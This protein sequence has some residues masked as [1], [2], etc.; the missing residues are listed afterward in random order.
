MVLSTLKHQTE[1]TL[2]QQQPG[3]DLRTTFTT[4]HLAQTSIQPYPN[5]DIMS[6]E[7]SYSNKRIGD[8]VSENYN[9]AAIFREFGIDFCCGG[10]ISLQEAC[11]KNG[12]ELTDVSSRLE[13]LS[14][15]N[16]YSGDNYAAWTPAFLIDYIV[17]THHQFVK[18][19][20]D[21]IAAYA[22]KVARVHGDRYPE[23]VEIHQTFQEL[24]MELLE[25]LQEE[26]QDVFPL[27]KRVAAKK[28]SGERPTETELS[29]L[30]EELVK[31]VSEHEHAGDLMAEIR[32]LS[33]QF[34]PP[35]DACATY[36]ILYQNLEGFEADLHK[37]VHLENNILFQK[38][39]ELVAA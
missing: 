37:H 23:N 29:E 17:N 21:E 9:A 12:V 10:G 22:A 25:H 2:L 15:T 6:I 34:T 19:K 32:S 39:E 1:I 14:A 27:I 5:S 31:M 18:Q 16:P 8:I 36:R 7:T 24:I 28:E 38:M 4:I 13:N 30:K 11:E 26:E 3:N 35:A 20:S 33:H